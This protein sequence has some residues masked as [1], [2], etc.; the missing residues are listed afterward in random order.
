M[1][2]EACVTH[3]VDDRVRRVAEKVVGVDVRIASINERVKDVD[4]KVASI[5]DRVANVDVA[6]V[7][8]SCAVSQ[9]GHV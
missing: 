5:T 6:T 2:E 1:L 4:N 8:S 9:N 7:P 3:T